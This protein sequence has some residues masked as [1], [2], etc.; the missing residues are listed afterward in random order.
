MNNDCI[1]GTMNIAYPYSS[2]KNTEEYTTIINTYIQNTKNPI[3]DTAYYYGNTKTEQILGDILQ[4]VN[5]MPK[6]ATKAN[7]WLH[8]DFTNGQYGQLS[9]VHLERQLSESLTNLHLDKVDT[10]FLHCPDPETPLFETL[11]ICDDLWRKERFDNFGISNYS[12]DQLLTIIDI[13]YNNSFNMPKVYQGMYNLICRKV[14]EIFP[15]LDEYNIDFW[16]Y[17][18]LA[19][20]LLTGKYKQNKKKD[21]NLEV[22]NL[23]AVDD[24][25][26][27][28][29]TIYQNIFWKPQIINGLSDFCDNEPSTCIHNSLQWL[30]HYS[31]M[32]NNDK[33]IMGVS[34][35]EQLIINMNALN[36]NN[37][38][39]HSNQIQKWNNMYKNIKEYSPNYFY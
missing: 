1:L 34:T 7:P 18:P 27:K 16:A 23:E 33:I 14:E 38:S 37:L 30:N 31:K 4:N 17:N 19:G 6:I 3:L 12:K 25:R 39:I 32:R 13:C 11:E 22:I 35:S 20:G 36:N 24:N 8:N 10:F 9:N 28:N 15:I 2:N 26:F 21:I 5:T 29:N